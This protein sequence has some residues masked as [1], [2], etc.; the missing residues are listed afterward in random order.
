[1]RRLHRQ[2]G[3]SLLLYVLM[4]LAMGGFLLEGYMQNARKEAEARKEQFDRDVLMQAKAALLQ[5]A[6]NYPLFYS[7]QGPGR[8]PCADTDNDGQSNTTYGSCNAL[9]RFPFDEPLLKTTDLRDS[10]GERLWYVPATTYM[11][12]FGGAINS[13]SMGTITIKDQA[14]QVLYD[15]SANGVAAVI[16]APGPAIDRN[17]TLQ[18]RQP[19]NGDDPNDLVADTDPAIINPVN[20]LDLNG[21]QDNATLTHLDS[22]D[23]FQLGP[24]TNA[25]NEIVINDRVVFIT[26]EEINHMAEKAVLQ[27]YRQA[28]RSY[29]KKI[30]GTAT[31]EYRFPWLD[32]Y[33]TTDLTK[34][35]AEMNTIKG[36]VPS[37]F[38]PYYDPGITSSTKSID[39]ELTASITYN[40]FPTPE[41]VLA[42]LVSINFDSDADLHI[43]PSITDNS[44]LVRYYWDEITSPSGWK[45]CPPVT[46]T[47]KDCNQAVSNPGV[48]DSTLPNNEIAIRVLKVTYSRDLTAG[49]PIERRFSNR[50]A[51]PLDFIAPDSTSH[52]RVLAEFYDWSNDEIDVSYVYDN[53]YYHSFDT[54]AP[55]TPYRYQ[56]GIRFYPSLPSWALQ[57]ND[58]WHD[59]VMLVFSPAYQAGT[60]S[61]ASCTPN[62]DDGVDDANECLLIDGLGGVANN[63]AGALVIAGEHDLVDEAGDGFQNDLG[64]LF[65]GKNAVYPV[66]LVLDWKAAPSPGNRPDSLLIMDPN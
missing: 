16:I 22:N 50:T 36:R 40:G 17:G 59:S 55:T 28:L 33:A 2:T 32:D 12:Q 63:K 27:A 41:V 30:W 29:Q 13:D 51:R 53:Y 52:A 4:I 21:T 44:D 8:L 14:G 45:L 5:Y 24:A 19:V 64:D 43:T 58:N 7:D 56:L 20:Y 47:E 46:G 9:G 3:F 31:A 66:Q 6:Y 39:S 54:F 57:E 23:G 11:Q 18:N 37:L 49:T 65:E 60:P 25:N 1:M 61:P 35:D 26:A 38:A 48:P 10:S 62:N 42:T 15:G 34:F